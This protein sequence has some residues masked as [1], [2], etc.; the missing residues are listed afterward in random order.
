MSRPPARPGIA[1]SGLPIGIGLVV[2]LLTLLFPSTP[3]GAVSPPHAQSATG[4]VRAG[5]FPDPSVIAVGGIYYAYSTQVY[6]DNVPVTTSVDLVHWSNPADALPQLPS[7]AAWGRTWAPSVAALPSGGY[8]MFYAAQ[9]AASGRQ[10][11]GRAI[12]PSPAGPFV[13]PSTAPFLCQEAMGGSIDPYVFSKDGRSY[14]LWKSDGEVVGGQGELWSQALDVTDDAVQGAPA[15]LLGADQLWEAG[16]V[17]G[18]AMTDNGSGV[19]LFFGGGHWWSADYA[20][21][22]VACA[23]PL[24]PCTD[25]AVRPLLGTGGADTGPGGPSLFTGPDG[26]LRMA[27]SAWSSGIVGY[28]E[29]SRALYVTRVAFVDGVPTLPD[30]PG[31]PPPA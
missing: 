8:V 5:D 27:Y 24:G 9:D 11:I 17:E 22:A 3:A 18:P 30:D 23:S 16:T 25:N 10:C 20:I 14:L 21:G 2:W 19:E 31:S 28:P 13:D 4:P 29:G 6:M 15:R 1:A 7:W 26:G 12:S